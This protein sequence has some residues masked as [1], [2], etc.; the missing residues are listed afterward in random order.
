MDK[1]TDRDI[2]ASKQPQASKTGVGSQRQRALSAS[3]KKGV[4]PHEEIL[5]LCLSLGLPGFS[6]SEAGGTPRSG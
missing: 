2:A 5:D 4:R 3:V 1:L 6:K